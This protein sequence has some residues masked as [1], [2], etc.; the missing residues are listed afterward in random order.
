M[1]QNRP[2]AKVLNPQ[3]TK[4]NGKWIDADSDTSIDF[5]IKP[6]RQLNINPKSGFDTV[7]LS[8]GRRNEVSREIS[9]VLVNFRN[10]Y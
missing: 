5:T 6:L 8:A 1:K 2:S 4:D 9:P 10:Q 7:E 3:K